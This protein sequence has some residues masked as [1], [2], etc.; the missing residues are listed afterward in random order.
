MPHHIIGEPTGVYKLF[1]GFV[2]ASEYLA[3]QREILSDPRID[4]MRY[5]INDWLAVEGYAA[6][7]GDAEY[8]AAFNRGTSFSNPR[9]RVAFVTANPAV[10]MLIAAASPISSL[11]VKAFSTLDEARAWAEAPH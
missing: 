4:S 6:G 7:I 1:T 5:I 8:S 3:T 10:R 9:L 2:D 11:P